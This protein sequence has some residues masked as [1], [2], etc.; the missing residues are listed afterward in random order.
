M[1]VVLGHARARRCR[2]FADSRD[3]QERRAARRAASAAASRPAAPPPRPCGRARSRSGRGGCGARASRA[4]A[5]SHSGVRNVIPLT[6]S[7]T[8]SASRASPRR[9]AHAAR[10]KTVTPR[11]HV[12][13]LQPRRRARDRL[14]ARRSVPATTVTRWPHSSQWAT[15]PNRFAPVPPPCGCVQ[16]RSVRSRMCRIAATTVADAAVYTGPLMP[17]GPRLRHALAA[18]AAALAL[19]PPRALAQGAGDDQYSDPFGAEE[20]AQ[21]TATRRR[22]RAPAPARRRAAPG[23]ARPP[24]AAPPPA[25]PAPAATAVRRRPH[26]CRTPASTP[27]C[28]PPAGALLLGAGLTLRAASV[29]RTELTPG[30]GGHRARPAPSSR[31]A[32]RPATSCS[33][34]ASSAPARRRSCAARCA[35]SASRAR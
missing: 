3:G 7:S 17:L 6:T 22:P 16:S 13:Q 24:D 35:R 4:A 2:A 20:Q 15:W 31:A 9:T 34:R 25:R 18:A 28:P 12:V 23:A 33:S 11:A 27:G 30:P 29:S 32:L 21:A 5:R 8:T 14:G 1:H 26:A 10:G 19:P